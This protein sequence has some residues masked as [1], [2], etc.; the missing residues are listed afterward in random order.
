MYKVGILKTD[1]SIIRPKKLK[2]LIQGNVCL[3][4]INDEEPMSNEGVFHTEDIVETQKD[5]T[6]S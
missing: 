4:V 3:Q 1:S 6:S 5:E 2:V